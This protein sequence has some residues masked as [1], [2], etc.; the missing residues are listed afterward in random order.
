MEYPKILYGVG[1]SEKG[2]F[3]NEH[4]TYTT[5]L[6]VD[7]VDEKKLKKNKFFNSVGELFKPKAKPK[8]KTKVDGGEEKTETDN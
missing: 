6:A 3:N 7:E 8:A 1:N 4:V 5:A 2:R